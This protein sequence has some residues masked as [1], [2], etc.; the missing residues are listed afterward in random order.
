MNI[1]RL[2]RENIVSSI[3]LLQEEIASTEDLFNSKIELHGR[4]RHVLAMSDVIEDVSFLL[5]AD[6]LTAMHRGSPDIDS[7][8]RLDYT[9]AGFGIDPDD[10]K[11]GLYWAIRHNSKR[12][13]KLKREKSS[14]MR[15]LA[16]LEALL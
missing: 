5:D 3:T 2:S 4:I 15:D 11:I 6:I 9:W 16:K 13:L 14:L 1:T 12:L 8:G 7:K 10:N